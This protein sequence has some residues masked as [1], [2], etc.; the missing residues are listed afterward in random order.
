MVELC[1]ENH[2]SHIEEQNDRL[3]RHTAS[4]L[5]RITTVRYYLLN[6][7]CDLTHKAT[8]EGDIEDSLVSFTDAPA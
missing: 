6:T 4:Y 5:E 8:D 2:A 3:T 7:S 1:F